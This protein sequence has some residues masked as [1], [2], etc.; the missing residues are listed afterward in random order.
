LE[1]LRG[2][3]EMGGRQEVGEELG[4]ADLRRNLGVVEVEV[5]VEGRACWS[6][7]SR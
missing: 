3:V 7:C 5:E 2:Q 6:L 1:L 4:A